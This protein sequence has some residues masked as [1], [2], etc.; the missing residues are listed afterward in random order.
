M[1]TTNEQS[2]LMNNVSLCR[3]KE[4]GFQHK[5]TFFRI[6]RTYRQIFMEVGILVMIKFD[7]FVFSRTWQIYIF[8]TFF[9]KLLISFYLIRTLFFQLS[10]GHNGQLICRANSISMNYVTYDF[11]TCHSLFQLIHFIYCVNLIYSF[12]QGL[13]CVKL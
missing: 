6:K 11:E 8:L 3:E 2:D 9:S 12:L 1:S 4:T 7:I 10:F 5:K 13:P